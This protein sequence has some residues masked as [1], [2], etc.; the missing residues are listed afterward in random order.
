[1]LDFEYPRCWFLGLFGY[2]IWKSVT[3]SP[4]AISVFVLFNL[5]FKVGFV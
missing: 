4:F 2:G 1:M 5:F 3:E